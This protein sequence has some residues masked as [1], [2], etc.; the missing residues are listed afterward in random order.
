MRKHNNRKASD[1]VSWDLRFAS[2][3]AYIL[4]T[5]EGEEWLGDLEERRSILVQN[6]WPNWFV[7][8][9]TLLRTCVLAICLIRIRYQDLRLSESAKQTE[10]VLF[11]N[12]HELPWEFGTYFDALS[13]AI[14]SDD[15]EKE[16]EIF[17]RYLE[18][19]PGLDEYYK[20]SWHVRRLAIR[21]HFK[22]GNV[23]KEMRRFERDYPTHSGVNT[24]LAEIYYDYKDYPKAA[25]HYLRAA[26]HR[27]NDRYLKTGEN[28]KLRDFCN[29]AIAA[30]AYDY[31][32]AIE[33]IG[34]AKE[35]ACSIDDEI[36]INKTLDKI[37]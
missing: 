7:V 12:E 4:P 17:E 32:L 25:T 37:F 33:I 18:N 2:L 8:M 34:Q 27:D 10:N 20:V 30:S 26:E 1:M 13:S 9:V 22:K 16:N 15:T 36:R 23:L 14:M 31:E 19:H 6:G 21:Q 3:L 24:V 5:K 28:R 35:C 11:L 29:A